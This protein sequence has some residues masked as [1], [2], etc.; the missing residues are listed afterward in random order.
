ML[1]QQEKLS[2]LPVFLLYSH[3]TLTRY[4]SV[5]PAGY[6]SIELNSDTIYLQTASDLSLI[7][8]SEPTRPK[9]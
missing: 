7:H 8:I 6:P 2:S 3:T 5:T 4:F 1:L 9:R